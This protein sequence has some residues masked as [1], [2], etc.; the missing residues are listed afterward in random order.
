M[1]VVGGIFSPVFQ[2]VLFFTIAKLL[3]LAIVLNCQCDNMSG[4]ALITL[5]IMHFTFLCE[6]KSF[7]C[8]YLKI[9][10][11]FNN[12]D[13]LRMIGIDN[14]WMKCVLMTA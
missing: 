4:V 1:L 8:K 12:T 2:S 14:G 6:E 7:L 10:F 3:L 5:E 9:I 11:F 13:P